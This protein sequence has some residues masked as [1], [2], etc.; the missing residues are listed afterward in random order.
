MGPGTCRKLRPL[1]IMVDMLVSIMRAWGW[2]D[3]C[4][5]MA[6]IQRLKRPRTTCSSQC[7]LER[8]SS[9]LIQNL[10]PPWVEVV[11]LSNL[12]SPPPVLLQAG[13]GV[14]TCTAPPHAHPPCC[15]P[16]CLQGSDAATR[17]QLSSFGPILLNY[18]LAQQKLSGAKK[19]IL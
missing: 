17:H 13:V 2:D 8:P 7:A 18:L 4:K 15:Y 16:S 6:A 10:A 12:A 3:L 5:V 14:A 9:F 1:W 19:F 11:G